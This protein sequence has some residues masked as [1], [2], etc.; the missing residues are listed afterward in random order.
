MCTGVETALIATAI[1]GTGTAAVGQYQQGQAQK[2]A[3]E[4]NAAIARNQAIAARQKAAFDAKRQRSATA[5]L[6]ARQRA[7]IAKAGVALEGTPLE[8]L[9]AT[10]EAGELDAQTIIYGGE[11]QSAGFR[12]QS[13]LSRL[14]AASSGGVLG[15][16]ATL[17]TGIGKT[18]MAAKQA[19]VGRASTTQ[20]GLS[21]G[22]TNLPA[23]AGSSA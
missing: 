4:F 7:A 5:D 18:G 13:E 9:E 22:S 12:S 20:S 6:L 3:A 19:G 2:Q 21:A 11:L 16:G 10:A 14:A 23:L 17:L 8:L 1:A 15:A